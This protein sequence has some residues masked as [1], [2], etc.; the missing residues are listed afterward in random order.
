MR[1]TIIP[2]AVFWVILE[3]SRIKDQ[4]KGIDSCVLVKMSVLIGKEGGGVL[5]IFLD[6]NKTKG[7]FSP[8]FFY[9]RLIQI[10]KIYT[11]RC[12]ATAF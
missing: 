8:M 1:R 7:T 11:R 10:R 9:I 6:E 3:T 2:I 5:R 12:N 4:K